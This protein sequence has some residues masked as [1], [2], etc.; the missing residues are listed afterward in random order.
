MYYRKPIANLSEQKE[1]RIALRKNMTSAEVVL[2]KILRG[3]NIGGYKFRRQQGIGPYILDFYCSEVKLCIEIDGSSHDN[4]F[5]YDEQRDK[6]LNS[7]GIRVVRFSNEQVWIN[8]DSVVN[9]ILHLVKE[10]NI[11]TPPLPLP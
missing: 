1:K 5:E 6:Y 2:W 8:I 4:K 9:D 7:M 3:R 10:R 11:T